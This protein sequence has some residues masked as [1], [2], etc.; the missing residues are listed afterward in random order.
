[1]PEPKGTIYMS[2]HMAGCQW[3]LNDHMHTLSDFMSSESI[4]LSSCLYRGWRSSIIGLIVPDHPNIVL[5]DDSLGTEWSCEQAKRIHKDS[6]TG[7]LRVVHWLTF[8]SNLILTFILVGKL[9]CVLDGGQLKESWA[10]SA[11]TRQINNSKMWLLSRIFIL[12]FEIYFAF[13]NFINL[14]SEG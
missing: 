1:M 13:L 12:V 4:P 14:L 10:P 11:T 6:Y 2:T 5:P 8:M 9:R 3:M 7:N